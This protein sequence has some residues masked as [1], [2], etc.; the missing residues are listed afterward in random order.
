MTRRLS[1]PMLLLLLLIGACCWT[2]ATEQIVAE[3]TTESLTTDLPTTTILPTTTASFTTSTKTRISG[4]RRRISTV[5]PSATP[6]L[7]LETSTA[8]P[9][10]QPITDQ[11][12]ARILLG[13]EDDPN[14]LSVSPIVPP[15][16]NSNDWTPIVRPTTRLSSEASSVSAVQQSASSTSSSSSPTLLIR[17]TPLLRP[18]PTIVAA[19]ARVGTQPSLRINNTT[20]GQPVVRPIANSP[21]TPSV[22]RFNIE[23]A[24]LPPNPNL[25]DSA[26]SPSAFP[27][28]TIFFSPQFDDGN[29]TDNSA[30]PGA[31]VRAN[32][33]QSTSSTTAAGSLAKLSG[34]FGNRIVRNRTSTLSPTTST[35]PPSSALPSGLSAKADEPLVDVSPSVL[36]TISPEEGLEGNSTEVPTLPG[37]STLTW[38]D[39]IPLVNEDR[40]TEV[41]SEPEMTT[42]ID[43]PSETS[44][45]GS[46]TEATVSVTDPKTSIAS[47]RTRP[48]RPTTTQQTT[49]TTTGRR[50]RPPTT[51]AATI[52]AANSEPPAPLS[53]TEL[54]SAVVETTER[55]SAR[56]LQTT[57]LAGQSGPI[58]LFPAKTRPPSSTQSPSTTIKVKPAAEEQPMTTIGWQ[59]IPTTT[60]FSSVPAVIGHS[61]TTP[62]V[63]DVSHQTVHP[64]T[65]FTDPLTTVRAPSTFIPPSTTTDHSFP[66]GSSDWPSTEGSSTL[67]EKDSTTIIAVSVSIAV[68]LCIALL[69]LLFI[70]LR[71][72]RARAVQGTCQPARMDAYNLDNVSQTNTWQRN[73][74]RSTLRSS[75]RSYL[76]QGFDDSVIAD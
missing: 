26:A 62:N 59:T 75:K 2:A 48:P 63:H 43:L 4:P 71:R 57:T 18:L 53:S 50:R 13:S 46:T 35:P 12:R 55:D 1:F 10:E 37:D 72:R 38:T 67:G 47:I 32:P 3:I 19:P 28:D 56:T 21:A 29:L 70:V 42:I 69:L 66:L 25:A 15:T 73:K 45:A 64:L 24:G 20:T 5:T 17:P 22:V 54:P 76:N 65:S 49:T 51:E 68:V 44:N 30:V 16:S 31:P 33:A 40:A 34:P 6:V 52:T 58:T 8:L 9:I 41:P 27:D 61:S 11:S 39:D 36:V 14:V 60:T 74:G 23:D 7:R